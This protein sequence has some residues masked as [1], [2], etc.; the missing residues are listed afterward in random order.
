MIRSTQ[1][2]SDRLD[3]LIKKIHAIQQPHLHDAAKADVLL[4]SEPPSPNLSISPP[5]LSF[6]DPLPLCLQSEMPGWADL[7]T[8]LFLRS[9]TASSSEHSRS[10][11]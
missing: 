3:G 7:S 2:I 1:E 6:P 9:P 5:S 4:V 10:D 11:G 8:G